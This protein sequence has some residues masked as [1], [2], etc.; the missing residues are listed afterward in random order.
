MDASQT[1]S[2]AATPPPSSPTLSPLSAAPA[3]SVSPVKKARETV[4]Y[5][6]MPP[7]VEISMK[8][9][10]SALLILLLKL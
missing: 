9:Q 2:A 6:V 4:F 8:K 3:P 10:M 1:F 5:S 7:S